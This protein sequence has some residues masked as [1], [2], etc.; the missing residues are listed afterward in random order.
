MNNHT[1]TLPGRFE[2]QRS[3]EEQ[4]RCQHFCDLYDHATV[5]ECR[6]LEKRLIERVMESSE[7][8]FSTLAPEK[9]AEFA[10]HFANI[11]LWYAAGNRYQ[12]RQETVRGLVSQ[13]QDEERRINAALPPREI[14]CRTCGTRMVANSRFDHDGQVLFV[15]TCPRGCPGNRAYFENGRE[16]DVGIPCL[17]CGAQDTQTT[18]DRSAPGILIQYD[19]S[20]CGH[21][22]KEQLVSPQEVDPEFEK[23]KARFC[24]TSEQGAEYEDHV[25]RMSSFTQ[26]MKEEEEKRLN[27]DLYDAAAKLRILTVLE[28]ETILSEA[29]EKEG[30]VRFALGAA[31]TRTGLF[32]GL[33]VPFTMH[34][35]S[36][37]TEEQSLK[38]IKAA[39]EAALGETNWALMK[40]G[41][42]YQLGL[43]EGRLKG[44]TGE[45]DK[46]DLVTQRMKHPRKEQQQE[47]EPTT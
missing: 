11:G 44:V 2:I 36:G 31:E 41:L 46:V 7:E 28:A 25:Y 4:A 40:D 43:V 33:V 10:Q 21:S 38:T 32:T 8:E 27:Q 19:C 20:A 42:V 14:V 34:D 12:Q 5:Q 17:Q 18:R 47:F 23:D 16:W 24:F 15:F 45:K 29:L 9:K 37:R 39:I 13:E 35:T 26:H 6:A 22:R 1:N 30:C 3:P